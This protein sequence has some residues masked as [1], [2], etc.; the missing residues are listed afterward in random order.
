MTGR[1]YFK[2][3]RL[4]L[5][6]CKPRMGA[7]QAIMLL[8]DV[9]EMRYVHRA[10]QRFTNAYVAHIA[11]FFEGIRALREDDLTAPYPKGGAKLIRSDEP[12]ASFRYSLVG[13]S[14]ID[15]AIDGDLHVYY[16]CMLLR[17]SD[18]SMDIVAE[19]KEV[20]VPMRLVR[21]YVGDMMPLAE[22]TRPIIKRVAS[23]MMRD[24]LR[25]ESVNTPA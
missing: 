1:P 16:T 6:R 7:H 18:G 21:Q 5:E 17:H 24:A 12:E 14:F 11:E 13:G 22:G 23:R 20:M 4:S 19:E 8:A 9:R 3:V 25:S 10:V 15:E 2:E